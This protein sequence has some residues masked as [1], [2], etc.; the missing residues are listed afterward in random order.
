[1]ETL[2]HSQPILE[3]WTVELDDVTGY[4]LR[5]WL[6]LTAKPTTAGATQYIVSRVRG[7]YDARAHARGIWQTRHTSVK[8]HHH[9]CD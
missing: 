7:P 3:T 9:A 2:L 5:S 6:G 4:F 8:V 1:M